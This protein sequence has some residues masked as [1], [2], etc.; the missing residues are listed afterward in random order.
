MKHV[1]L[2]FFIGSVALGEPFKVKELFF[3]DDVKPE[4]L[5]AFSTG[6]YKNSEGEALILKR[7]QFSLPIAEKIM[8]N[9]LTQ[10][11]MQFAPRSAPYPGMV[12]KDQNCKDTAKFPAK[13]EDTEKSLFWFSEMPASEDFTFAT[14]GNRKDVYQSQYLVIYCKSSQLL[15]DIRYF[16]PLGRKN[17]KGG[18][19]VATCL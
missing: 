15:F 6:K 1:I 17:L 13:I 11:K 4:S 12:T 3:A 7:E 2:L 19:A 10:L 18:R 9:R 16:V 14:C 8:K 5:A